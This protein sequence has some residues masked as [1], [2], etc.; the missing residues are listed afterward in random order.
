MGRHPEHWHPAGDCV[1]A[2]SYVVIEE[3]VPFARKAYRR[4]RRR[5]ARLASRHRPK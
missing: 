3:T 1:N 2:S 5:G 4:A